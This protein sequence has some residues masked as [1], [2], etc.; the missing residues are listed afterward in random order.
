MKERTLRQ[1][2]KCSMSSLICRPDASDMCVSFRKPPEDRELVRGHGKNEVFK[3]GKI[4][5]N[6][7]KDLKGIMG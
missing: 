6:R 3:R 2:D 1:E 4:G 7:T 5:C